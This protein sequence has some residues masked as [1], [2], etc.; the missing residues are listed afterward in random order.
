MASELLDRLEHAGFAAAKEYDPDSIERSVYESDP[1][2]IEAG[3][4]YA[5][6]VALAVLAE[7][8]QR[9]EYADLAIPEM[10]AELE[11]GK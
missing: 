3:R 1:E 7:L 8:E 6:A 9:S 2:L 4:C 11:A 10:R 5:R